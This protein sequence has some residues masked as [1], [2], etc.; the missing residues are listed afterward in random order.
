MAQKNTLKVQTNHQREITSITFSP[1]G[2][3]L[4]TTSDDNTAKLWEADTKKLLYTF[5]GDYDKTAFSPNGQLFLLSGREKTEVRQLSNLN[6]LHTLSMSSGDFVSFSLDGQMIIRGDVMILGGVASLEGWSVENGKRLYESVINDD[7]HP[8]AFTFS[9]S[10]KHLLFVSERYT[11]VLCRTLTGRILLEIRIHE[12]S[13]K[14]I[15]SPDTKYLAN[16][17]STAVRLTNIEEEEETHFREFNTAILQ[18]TFSSDEKYLLIR[19]EDGTAKLWYTDLEKHLT[20]GEESFKWVSA[21]AFSPDGQYLCIG[22]QDKTLHLKNLS[23]GQIVW[24][25]QRPTSPITSVVFS[26]DGLHLLTQTQDDALQLYEVST[27]KLLQVFSGPFQSF[28]SMGFSPAKRYVWASTKQY[29]QLWEFDTGKPLPHSF[30]REEGEPIKFSSNEN[31]LLKYLFGEYEPS[32]W[33]AATG[34]PLFTP[35]SEEIISLDFLPNGENAVVSIGQNAAKIWHLFEGKLLHVFP[36]SQEEIL[37]VATFQGQA[38]AIKN[39]YGDDILWNIN[40]GEKMHTLVKGTVGEKERIYVNNMTVSPD[41]KYLLTGN[42][43]G[44][45]TLWNIKDGKEVYTLKEFYRNDTYGKTSIQFS[46]DGKHIVASFSQRSLVILFDAKTGKQV[47]TFEAYNGKVVVTIFSPDGKYVLS[48]SDDGSVR[49]WE[50]ATDKPPEFFYRFSCAVVSLAFSSNEESVL[51]G[52]KNHSA[53]LWSFSEQKRLHILKG[54]QDQVNLVDFPLNPQVIITGSYDNTVKF[55][56]ARNGQLL[57]T[58]YACFEDPKAWV[59]VTPEGKYDG[60]EAGLQYLHYVKETLQVQNLPEND[61]HRIKGLLKKIT[62]QPQVLLKEISEAVKVFLSELLKVSTKQ[63]YMHPVTFQQVWSEKLRLGE[64]DLEAFQF[65]QGK[66]NF[67]EQLFA[68]FQDSSLKNLQY[69]IDTLKWDTVLFPHT[70]LYMRSY[71]TGNDDVRGGGCGNINLSEE[72]FI[73]QKST[74]DGV[75]LQDLTEGAYR[76]KGAKYDWQY[77]LFEGL[78]INSSKGNLLEC[79]VDFSYKS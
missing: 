59:V 64:V 11:H 73:W 29:M 3:Y 68:S 39:V 36:I 13:G 77:E 65:G 76:L 33:E 53:E 28:E 14:L 57:G 60:N 24:T 74:P 42:I 10:G 4:L 47:N 78:E 55:W 19:L 52:L 51:V 6:L 17:L 41:G 75:T 1:N 5:E 32:L 22:F 45:I 9:S 43:E 62:D 23:T 34:K 15:F 30:M 66:E 69:F 12:I 58:W 2:K 49:V 61:V 70:Q 21:I 56:N 71:N 48:G 27:G 7:D 63:V 37:A 26:S 35:I 50:I 18:V 20:A 8:T 25:S 72:D 46:P 38:Y 44:M 54:H 67:E 40:K 31:Y 16:V 79:I